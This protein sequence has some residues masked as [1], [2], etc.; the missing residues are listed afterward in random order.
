MTVNGLTASYVTDG[1][2]AA[3]G[4]GLY[5]CAAK[6][7]Q[8]PGGWTGS[9]GYRTH[10]NSQGAAQQRVL[11]AWAPGTP[12]F[13]DDREEPRKP[14]RLQTSPAAL[15]QERGRGATRPAWDGAAASGPGSGLGL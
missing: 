3:K 12:S 13:P 15:L 5:R 10:V 11:S 4:P 8:R 14:E 9:C 1:L 2:L 6:A 7:E